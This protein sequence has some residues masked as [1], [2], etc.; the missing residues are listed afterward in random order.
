MVAVEG[1]VYF[2]AVH[3]R[4]FSECYAFKLSIA[5]YIAITLWS[6]IVDSC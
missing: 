3:V 1:D 5:S 6:D 2:E 4:C